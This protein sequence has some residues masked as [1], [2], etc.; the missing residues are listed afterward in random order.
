MAEALLHACVLVDTGPLVAILHRNDAHHAACVE[1]LKSIAPPLLTCWPVLTEAAW[2]L[3]DSSK[4]TEQLLSGAA[5]GLLRL[6]PLEEDALPAL[7][8]LMRKYRRLGVQLADVALVHLAHRERI[9]TIFT[10]D[11]RDFNVLRGSAGK[12]FRLLP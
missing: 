3:R 12:P 4:A 1:A 2:L 6:L 7:S 10:L 9:N 5:S 11:R 8:G